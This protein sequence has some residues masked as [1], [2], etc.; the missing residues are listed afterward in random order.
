MSPIV[1]LTSRAHAVEVVFPGAIWEKASATEAGWSK[2]K[3]EQAR[4]AFRSLPAASMVVIDRGRIIVEWGDSAKR[5]K[6]H[7]VRKGRRGVS[8]PRT[9]ILSKTNW[10][11]IYTRALSGPCPRITGPRG[12]PDRPVIRYPGPAATRACREHKSVCGHKRD[13]LRCVGG[14]YGIDHAAKSGQSRQPVVAILRPQVFNG[15]GPAFDKAAFGNAPSKSLDEGAP[16][17]IERRLVQNPDYWH[18]GLLR[19]PPRQ[20]MPSPR[21]GRQ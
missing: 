10:G 8:S 20:A 4:Q 17:L 1:A 5:I 13:T 2:Q 19:E 7:S 3:L 15:H 21:Q 11:A 6:V 9:R 12:R 18:R 14:M 16:P